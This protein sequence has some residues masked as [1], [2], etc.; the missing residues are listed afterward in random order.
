MTVA[1]PVISACGIETAILPSSV[2][3]NHTAPEFNGFTFHD[4]TDQMPLILTQ[5]KKNNTK[6]NAFYTGYVTKKQIPI[7]LQI[8]KETSAEGALKIIDPVMADN[9]KL[10][11]GFDTTFPQE[12]LKLCQGADYIMPNLTEAALLLETEYKNTGYNK[13]YIDTLC[14]QLQQ[15]TQAKNVIITG[16]S[17]QQDKLGVAV[18]SENALNFYFTKKLQKSMHGTGDLF[19]SSFTGALLRGKTALEAATIAANFVVNAMEKTQED[20]EHWYG[21]KFEQALPELINSLN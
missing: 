18:Y 14:H 4:L 1:L 10:Y 5:W 13:T 8:I 2:L 21:V 12:M 6:F 9:G 11:S 15:K 7:I 19:A 3:S 17:F 16:V 20:K